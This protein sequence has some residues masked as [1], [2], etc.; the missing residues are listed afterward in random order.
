MAPYR[1][2]RHVDAGHDGKLLGEF[3]EKGA[4]VNSPFG[5][6]RYLYI[7]SQQWN[8]TI[9]DV[10]RALNGL[11]WNRL[12]IDLPLTARLVDI[13]EGSANTAGKYISIRNDGQHPQELLDRLGASGKFRSGEDRHGSRLIF[14][15]R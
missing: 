2:H 7:R 15:P 13:L 11:D 6:T 14:D 9:D 10:E 1:F 5:H 4:W 8:G 12:V 3:Y